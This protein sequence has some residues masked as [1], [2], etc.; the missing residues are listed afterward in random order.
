M[1]QRG[2]VQKGLR[3]SLDQKDTGSFGLGAS[4]QMKLPQNDQKP[5]RTIGTR[6]YLN[7][8]LLA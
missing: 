8:N 7:L 3:R 6:D 1:W 4:F 5:D 2:A